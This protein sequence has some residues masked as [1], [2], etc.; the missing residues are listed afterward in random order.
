MFDSVS[1]KNCL[2]SN[3]IVIG[4]PLNS[5]EHHYS[6]GRPE[7]QSNYTTEAR[8][9][10]TEKDLRN[11]T[12]DL[13][14]KAY[15]FPNHSNFELAITYNN[16]NLYKTTNKMD[17]IP[18]GMTKEEQDEFQ[19]KYIEYN[20]NILLD[21]NE[22]ASMYQVSM[23]NPKD[24]YQKFNYDAI[25]FKQDKVV[26]DTITQEVKPKDTN[27][28]AFDY[29]NAE[30]NKDHKYNPFQIRSIN[31]RLDIR[32]QHKGYKDNKQ[33]W[34]PIANRY[35]QCPIENDIKIEKL[36]KEM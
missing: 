21:K 31:S 23:K 14:E 32:R 8:M 24:Q 27:I 29:F 12:A 5:N 22:R 3:A 13:N 4:K 2:P 25:Q 7:W 6:I 26:T 11:N 16:K 15:L 20:P 9:K 28:W 33:I 35:F 18:K 10:F 30:K 34:D 1:L 19:K 17:Y 36:R